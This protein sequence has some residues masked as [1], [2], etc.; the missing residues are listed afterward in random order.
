[1]LPHLLCGDGSAV[2]AAPTAAAASGRTAAA[3]SPGIM[4]PWEARHAAAARVAAPTAASRRRKV[5]RA[6]ARLASFAD[7][8]CS[9]K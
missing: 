9:S 5:L 4:R 7:H 1:M 3:P 8:A 6:A 2:L